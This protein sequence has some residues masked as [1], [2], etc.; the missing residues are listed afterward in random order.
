MG[1]PGSELSMKISLGGGPIPAKIALTFGHRFGSRGSEVLQPSIEGIGVDALVARLEASEELDALVSRAFIACG[2]SAHTGK[3]A[4][5]AKIVQRTVLDDAKLDESSLLVRIMDQIEGPD[6]RCLEEMRRAEQRARDSGELGA[7]ARGAEKPMTREVDK[8][9]EKYPEAVLRSLE[10]LGL[11]SATINWD[12]S[13]YVSGMSSLGDSIL[14]EL[15][16]VTL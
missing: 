13:A 3:R 16:E 9:A 1:D 7:I 6:I 5:L 12:G 11:I 8:A 15:H 10:R 4:L 2:R 14:D